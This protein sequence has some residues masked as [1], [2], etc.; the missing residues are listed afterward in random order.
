LERQARRPVGGG[1]RHHDECPQLTLQGVRWAIPPRARWV[2]WDFTGELPTPV[3]VGEE[4]PEVARLRRALPL[5]RP[6]RCRQC[7]QL[8]ARLGDLRR[9]A[10][11]MQAAAALAARQLRTQYDLTDPQLAE[12]L[13]FRPGELPVWILEEIDWCTEGDTP[14]R[15]MMPSRRRWPWRRKERDD[16][17]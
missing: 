16:G 8:L 9:T 10:D 17:C 4:W 12:L 7:G 1:V 14:V 13:S 11:A 15:P 5:G 3:L 6:K 2:T